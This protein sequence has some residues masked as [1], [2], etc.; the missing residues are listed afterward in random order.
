METQAD[1][2]APAQHHAAGTSVDR[3]GCRRPSLRGL[4]LVLLACISAASPAWTQA[5][6]D[7][8]EAQLR[9][10]Q[11][12]A[13]ASATAGKVKALRK[14]LQAERQ[15]VVATEDERELN[16]ATIK[17]LEQELQAAEA[18][19]REHEAALKAAQDTRARGLQQAAPRPPVSAPPDAAE[20]LR[21]GVGAVNKRDYP[22]AAAWFRKAADQ[23]N[24]EAQEALGMMYESGMGVPQDNAEAASWFRKAAEQEHDGA[25]FR[26][27]GMYESGKGVPQDPAEAAAW[28][29]K[30]ADQG[31]VNAQS[32]LGY[33]YERGSGVPRDHVQAHI[34]Y[35][36]AVA[37]GDFFSESAL[38]SIASKL[39]PAQIADAQRRARE[40][41]PKPTK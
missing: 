2:V 5:A 16:R 32:I 7:D 29:R 3:R 18:R 14:A 10:R 19:Q 12:A 13:A 39:T 26:L 23:G 36:L 20:A 40:W 31:H 17:V 27:G 35:S 41:K 11:A 34:W 21:H 8:A 1:K 28:Y 25:Q 37:Q 9:V 30:A 4:L 24:A 15:R 22:A 38:K 6:F 33:M